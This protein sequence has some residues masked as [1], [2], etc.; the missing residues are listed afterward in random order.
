ME[1]GVHAFPKGM[2]AIVGLEFKL[3][4]SN[5]AVQH[6]TH[7]AKG[8]EWELVEPYKSSY[9]DAINLQ[10]NKYSN[11]YVYRWWI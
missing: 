8:F 7:Y 4:D 1:K 5:I 10:G 3:A 2:N 11:R 9:F 6:F